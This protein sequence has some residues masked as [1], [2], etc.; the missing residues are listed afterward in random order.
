M[1]AIVLLF[2][3]LLI[4]SRAD[5][6]K[7]VKKID[8]LINSIENSNTLTMISRC[9]TAITSH[10]D[11][12]IALCDEYYS[13]NNKIFKIIRKVDNIG[14]SG[15]YDKLYGLAPEEI[16]TTSLEVFYSRRN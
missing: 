6:Q 3:V 10:S 16:G 9:D 13:Y 11:Y 1:R 2:Y 4:Y 12:T 15:F 8:S 14:F 7:L 5:S